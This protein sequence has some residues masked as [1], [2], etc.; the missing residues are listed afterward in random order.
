MQNT[1]SKMSLSKGRREVSVMMANTIE[2]APLSPT[3]DRKP[4]CLIGYLRN[5]ARMADTAIG[6]ATNSKKRKMSKA[7][8]KT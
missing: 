4:I 3:N 7:G 6:R 5:G 8:T 2:A 1:M